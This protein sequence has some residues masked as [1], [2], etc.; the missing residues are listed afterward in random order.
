[1]MITLTKTPDG[2]FCFFGGTAL[3]VVAFFYVE[4][5]TEVVVVVDLA[6]KVVFTFFLLT[7]EPITFLRLHD[8]LA[9]LDNGLDF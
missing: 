1:M 2:L 3:V 4:D 7:V 6:A 5:A 9:I 8:V